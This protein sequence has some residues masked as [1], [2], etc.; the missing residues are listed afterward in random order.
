M[1]LSLVLMW[2][3]GLLRPAGTL[4]RAPGPRPQGLMVPYAENAWLRQLLSQRTKPERK[5][6]AVVEGHQDGF[7]PAPE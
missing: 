7:R 2:L 3:E 4:D 5:A 6:A 1:K